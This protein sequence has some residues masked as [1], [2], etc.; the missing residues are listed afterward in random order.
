MKGEN[1]WDEDLRQYE[2]FF[3]ALPGADNRV[4]T[5]CLI[6]CVMTVKSTAPTIK[7]LGTVY[8]SMKISVDHLL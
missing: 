4:L 1:V 7:P 2:E 8:H 6:Y 5:V 3:Y